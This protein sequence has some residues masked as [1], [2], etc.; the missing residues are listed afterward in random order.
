VHLEI[1][2]KQD[3][4]E[5]WIGFKSNKY[6]SKFKLFSGSH[7]L[8]KLKNNWFRRNLF[9]I[10]GIN[11]QIFLLINSFTFFF[12]NSLYPE[13]E[14]NLKPNFVKQLF[15]WIVNILQITLICGKNLILLIETSQLNC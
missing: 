1:L 6:Y 11:F 9:F 3:L 12:E 15:D 14:K 7:P 2:N 10:F 5:E 13:G 8:Q 4:L